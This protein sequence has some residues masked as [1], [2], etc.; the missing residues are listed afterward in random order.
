MN[1]LM[2]AIEGITNDFELGV[3]TKPET[4]SIIIGL[5]ID[6]MVSVKGKPLTLQEWWSMAPWQDMDS[7]PK[8]SLIL[9]K[10]NAGNV[11]VSRWDFCYECWMFNSR[12]FLN[13]TGWLTI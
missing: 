13:P 3:S 12:E 10:D 1:K 9:L 5:V 6:Y 8:D 2:A 7:T 11:S 4:N